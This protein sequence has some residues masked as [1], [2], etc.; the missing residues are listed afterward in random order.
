MQTCIYHTGILK[1]E[2]N[3]TTGYEMTIQ[4]HKKQGGRSK[5]TEGKIYIN[6]TFYH[7]ES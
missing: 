7:K 5:R 4:E 3:I 6:F 2:E 1:A